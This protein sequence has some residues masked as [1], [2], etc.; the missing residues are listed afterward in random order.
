MSKVI[1]RRSFVVLGVLIYI[2]IFNTKK[3]LY[4]NGKLMGYVKSVVSQKI[5]SGNIARSAEL[6]GKDKDKEKTKEKQTMKYGKCS[7]CKLYCLV[8][9]GNTGEELCMSCAKT[10]KK[11]IDNTEK[12]NEIMGKTNSTN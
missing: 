1:I 8:V 7:E 12:L 10:N 6:S 5:L 2:I 4:L 9:A 11:P 3:E